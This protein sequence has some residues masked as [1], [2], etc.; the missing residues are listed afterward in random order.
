MNSAPLL[1][2]LFFYAALAMLLVMLDQWG[3]K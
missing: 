1:Q 3:R 2:V